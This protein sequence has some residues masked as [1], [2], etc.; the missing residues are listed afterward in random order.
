M[1]KFVK[2]TPAAKVTV[3]AVA[4]AALLG[5]TGMSYAQLEKIPGRP[6]SPVAIEQGAKDAFDFR[7][8]TT[9]LENPWSVAWGPDD[10]LW[11][12]ER[13]GTRVTRVDPVTGVKQSPLVLENVV[14]GS[15]QG[16]LGLVLH[17]ELLKG[18]GNDYVY[19]SHTYDATGGQGEL[20]RKGKIVRYTYD[21]A[22]QQL[23]EPMDI[24]TGI[25]AGTDHNSGRMTM[26]PD[27]MI[28]YAAGDQGHNQFRAFQ[29]P[30]EAQRLPTADEV[31]D[32]AWTAYTG[33]IL[34]MTLDGAIPED[35]PEIEGVRSH[36]FSYGHRNPQGMAFSSSGTL[37]S[38][39]H[40]PSSDDELNAVVSG[41]N[42]GWPNVSGF[43]DDTGYAYINWSQSAADATWEINPAKAPA[44]MPR[45]A[46]SDF[47]GDIVE[48]VASYWVVEDGF[49]FN[50]Q[51]GIVCDPTIAPSSVRHYDAGEDGIA[52]WDNS[53]I[54]T[55]LKHGA[56]Y[57]QKLSEDGQT[58]EGLPVEWL[59]TQNRYRDV[60]VGPDNKTVY[61]LTDNSGAATPHYGD[62]LSTNVHHNP[63]AIL[64]FT[65]NGGN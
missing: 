16:L 56:V 63:G 35:N 36:I 12:T 52:E 42:Y 5:G 2:R 44:E 51:C 45:E 47:A 38:V 14:V 4:I 26:G 41:G 1:M 40:G 9:G 54:I 33:K 24:L 59:A 3:A 37:Y 25:P 19:V 13:T 32:E 29:L 23:I 27:G 21:Q 28:Y 60:L 18:T 31:A 34:R 17:P 20:D 55:A 61:V 46:E 30:I 11:I 22:S 50:E 64:M 58:A 48:P 10:F 15:Q 39:E 7:V 53:A 57:V 6:M 8:L 49:P 62:Q 65:Y 43:R